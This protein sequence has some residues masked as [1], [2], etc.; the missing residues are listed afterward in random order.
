MVTQVK[1]SPDEEALARKLIQ[2]MTAAH[3]AALM[4]EMTGREITRSALIGKVNRGKERV[5]TFRKPATVGVK[6]PR[7]RDP[8]KRRERELMMLTKKKTAPV[9]ALTGMK[10]RVTDNG[11]P[12]RPHFTGESAL[13]RTCQYIAGV[14]DKTKCGKPSVGPWCDEHTKLVFLPPDSKKKRF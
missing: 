3:A 12:L 10:L 7:P 5:K 4:T 2:Q 6:T 9:M 13:F 8:E 14:E 11:P 1:W